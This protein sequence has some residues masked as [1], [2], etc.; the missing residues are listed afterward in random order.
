MTSLHFN[1]ALTVDCVVFSASGAVVLIRRKNPPFQGQYALPGGFV[2]EDET[3]ELA[4]VREAKEETNL[5]LKNLQLVGIYSTPG[6]DPR[7]RTVSA[8]FLAEADLSQLR[9]GD[10]ATEA[11]LVQYWQEKELAFDHAQIL[12]DAWKLHGS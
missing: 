11:E 1:C 12:H 2:D 4:C 5:E 3:V 8:A 6:R 7:G 10:D 9:A